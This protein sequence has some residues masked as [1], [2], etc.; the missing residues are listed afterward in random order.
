[1]YVCIYIYIYIYIYGK[2]MVPNI[3]EYLLYSLG[4]SKDRTKCSFSCVI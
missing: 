3:F 1:M 2:N 4:M